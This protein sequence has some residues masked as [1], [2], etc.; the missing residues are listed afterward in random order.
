MEHGSIAERVGHMLEPVKTAGKITAVTLICLTLLQLAAGFAGFRPAW[1]N[2]DEFDA[3]DLKELGINEVNVYRIDINAYQTV[4][5]TE[6]GPFPEMEP[7]IFVADNSLTLDEQGMYDYA[8]SLGYTDDTWLLVTHADS[9]RPSWGAGNI[10][11]SLLGFQVKDLKE[12][13]LSLDFEPDYDIYTYLTD[14]FI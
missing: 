7:F 2:Y 13:E 6:E 14:I 5:A 12:E 8:K 3:G 9:I 4:G 11:W 10:T 1:M